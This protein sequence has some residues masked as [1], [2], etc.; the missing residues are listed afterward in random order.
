MKSPDPIKAIELNHTT[1]NLLNINSTNKS[2]KHIC[3]DLQINNNNNN[4]LNTNNSTIYSPNKV[5][6]LSFSIPSSFDSPK[7]IN[8]PTNNVDNRYESLNNDNKS[9]LIK[10]KSNDFNDNKYYS[11]DYMI[12][13]NHMNENQ[14]KKSYSQLTAPLSSNNYDNLDNNNHIKKKFRHDK[15]ENDKFFIKNEPIIQSTSNK[16]TH[17]NTIDETTFTENVL[18]TEKHE[19]PNYATS[20][21]SSSSS[22][23]SPAS[24]AQDTN[25]STPSPSVSKPI[26]PLRPRK[27][28]NRPSKTPVDERPHACTVAGCP[29][30]FSRSD[31]LT[32]H[33][34]IHTGDKPFKCTVCSRAFSRSDH[35]TTHIRTHTGEKPFSCEICS[36]RFARSDERK[37]HTKIHQKISK[38]NVNSTNAINSSPPVK[39]Y[40][41]ST[42]QQQMNQLDKRADTT[43][44]NK[45]VKNKTNDAMTLNMLEMNRIYSNNNNNESTNLNTDFN[46][47]ASDIANTFNKNPSN[48]YLN[49]NSY[50]SR[51]M[52]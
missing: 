1:N 43:K 40:S 39:K 52:L 7:S 11:N 49:M 42:N 3:A 13:P 50:T 10:T 12:D 38:N 14:P 18:K 26:L 16:L 23:S 17:R 19:Y 35:L 2:N 32:R 6:K 22:I 34:R 45:N 25:H 24:P 31:E 29:R 30:R 36:R 21:S 51:N 8:I 9:C 37:R 20:T 27:Y 41:T 48:D 4:N 47:F 46:F 5:K 28:P 33:L 44:M 15:S